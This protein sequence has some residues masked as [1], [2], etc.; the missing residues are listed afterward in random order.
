MV[1]L[2]HLR[3]APA[4]LAARTFLTIEDTASMVRKGLPPCTLGSSLATRMPS[5]TAARAVL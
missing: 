3:V 4:A 1:S 5:R 2:A